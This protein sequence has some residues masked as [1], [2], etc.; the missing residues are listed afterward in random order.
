MISFFHLATI[1]ILFLSLVACSPIL[2]ISSTPAT[3]PV[4]Q[5]IT[6]NPKSYAALLSNAACFIELQ[7]KAL[8]TDHQDDLKIAGIN[9]CYDLVLEINPANSSYSGSMNLAYVNESNSAISELVF[10]LYPNTIYNY[11]GKLVVNHVEISNVETKTRYLQ[12]DQS[13]LSVSLPV[14]LAPGEIV[15]LEMSFTGEIPENTSTY[16]IFNFNSVTQ[17]MALANWFPILAA[18]DAIGWHTEDIQPQGDAVTSETS[19]F[20]ATIKI[21]AAWQVASTGVSLRDVSKNAY[22]QIEIV[23]GPT[24]DFMIVAGVHFSVTERESQGVHIRQW[25][26]PENQN[27]QAR[28]VEVVDNA[29]TIF[30]DLFDDY[31]F[32][33]LDVVTMRLN[34]A[35]GVEYPGLI[36]I[37]QSLYPPEARDV[38]RLDI[39]IA[40]EVAH[41][42]WYSLVGNDVQRDPWQDEALATYSS[43]LYLEKF[44]PSY[45]N[46]TLLYFEDNVVDFEKSSINGDYRISDPLTTYKDQGSAYAIIVYQKGALFFW[47]LRRKIGEPAFT[48]ALDNYYSQ[49][50]YQLA[51]PGSLLD[52]FENQCGCN[53]DQFYQDWGMLN[54]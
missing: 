45:L 16:G 19:L 35:S 9:A 37:D 3:S 36:L 39:V 27:D 41:Q 6:Q 42:W 34:N 26:L 53:L 49:N 52:S 28:A 13:V 30:A 1:F 54:K 50:I 15:N 17:T 14:S 22:R 38:N 5:S 20:H 11:A 40:H 7:I 44:I 43:L 47:N 48:S 32:N 4:T 18:H 51:T 25:S 12:T 8:K 33:E 2:P 31:P 21:P 10:R 29:L 23:S 24:R 46:G